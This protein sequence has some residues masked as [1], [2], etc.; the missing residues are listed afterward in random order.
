MSGKNNIPPSTPPYVDTILLDCSRSNSEEKKGNNNTNK[1]LYT[2]KLGVGVRLNAGDKVSV[3]QGFVSDRGCGGDVIEFTGKSLDISYEVEYTEQTRLQP[4]NPSNQYPFGTYPPEGFMTL[5]YENK[6]QSFL[7]KDNEVNLGISYFKSTNG[8]GYFHLPRR[9]DAAKNPFFYSVKGGGGGEVG[10]ATSN[11]SGADAGGTGGSQGWARLMISH[12]TKGAQTISQDPVNTSGSLGT[13]LRTFGIVAQYYDNYANGMASPPLFRTNLANNEHWGEV[14]GERLAWQKSTIC[15]DDNYFYDNGNYP[16]DKGEFDNDQNYLGK[17]VIDWAENKTSTAKSPA[18]SYMMEE[19]INRCVKKKNDGKRYTIFKMSDVYR[20]YLDNTGLYLPDLDAESIN[21]NQFTAP[22]ANL[23]ADGYPFR[24]R[25]REPAINDFIKYQEIK[26]LKVPAGY[27]APSNVSEELT[28]QLNTTEDPSTINIEV[29]GGVPNFLAVSPENL[30]IDSKTSGRLRVGTSVDAGTYKPFN[31]ATSVSFQALSHHIYNDPA[32]SYDKTN[33]TPTRPPVPTQPQPA[34]KTFYMADYLSSYETIAFK[35]P[36]FVEAG[37]NLMKEIG[38]VWTYAT[39]EVFPEKGIWTLK[40]RC[41]IGKKQIDTEDG[42]DINNIS[43]QQIIYPCIAEDVTPTNY[44]V[45]KT[46][47]PW[48]EDNLK[49]LKTYFDTQGGYPELFES[50]REYEDK[51]TSN[52]CRFFHMNQ[53]ANE[54]CTNYDQSTHLYSEATQTEINPAYSLLGD[55]GMDR[56]NF[57]TNHILATEAGTHMRRIGETENSISQATGEPHTSP[58]TSQYYN[59]IPLP[60]YRDETRAEEANGGDSA[61]DLYYGMF[62]RVA[63]KIPRNPHLFTHGSDLEDKYYW[64]VAITTDG[65]GFN[66]QIFNEIRNSTGFVIERYRTLGYDL[67]F[68]A[69]GNASICLYAGYLDSFINRANESSLLGYP[70]QANAQNAD[71]T[72]RPEWIFQ[73]W[74]QYYCGANNPLITFDTQA[75]RFSFQQLYTAEQVGNVSTAGNG[76]SYPVIDDADN[77]VYKVNKNLL[78]VSFA[79][80]MIPYLSEIQAKNPSQGVNAESSNNLNIFPFSVMDSHGGIFLENMA[81]PENKWDDSLWGILGFSYNQFNSSTT[82]SRQTMINDVVTID[83]IGKPTTNAN[84]V[85]STLNEWVVNQIGVPLYSQQI[86]P[87][88]R[89]TTTATQMKTELANAVMLSYP[90]INVT[91]TSAQ[92]NAERL[93]RKMLK[94]YFLIKSDIIDNVSYIG[95]EDSGQNLPVIYVVNKENAFGDFFFQADSP[96]EFTIT[97]PHTISSITTSI[98]NPDMTL[99]TLTD[100]SSIIYK[101]TKMNKSN[102]MPFA[103]ILAESQQKK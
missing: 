79:P 5:L 23:D 1:A 48:T 82:L 11:L 30:K 75:S 96:I 97:R 63:I 90:S 65:I 4:L 7:L 9:Y 71:T 38:G 99:A 27:N 40:R 59:S 3:H 20:G 54:Y 41:R 87:S 32:V 37:R 33:E 78:A 80:D 29:G 53:G 17:C 26:N 43:I 101:I 74:R 70:F 24:G 103:Q 39:E 21:R 73:N 35:R 66:Q 25:I 76:E 60:F 12:D 16:N 84:I 61:S 49:L 19:F 2:N 13:S 58:N 88:F 46:S 98:H 18:V 14:L 94:P 50:L 10:G 45:I 42:M 36:D 64:A 51:I 34:T 56:D 100:D 81:V 69:Y 93:P 77:K 95:G 28:N 57:Q 68:N 31:C 67:H 15:W 86:P 83:N 91:Q 62:K 6:K 8:E 44:S 52:N 72:Y 85:P 89:P 102:L 92:I 22:Y 47:I 55:D